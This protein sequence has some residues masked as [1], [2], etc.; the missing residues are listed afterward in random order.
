MD[1]FPL[2]ITGGQ[3]KNLAKLADWLED[4]DNKDFPT[5]FDMEHVMHS[6]ES[7]FTMERPALAEYGY[8]GTTACALGHGPAAGVEPLADESWLEYRKRAFGTMQDVDDVDPLYD[9]LFC[10]MWTIT[11]NTAS[12]AVKRIRYALE[13]GIPDNFQDQAAR[14][15]PLSYTD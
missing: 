6:E 11:D 1:H 14:R 13:H 15:A 10:A 7:G 2:R 4:L 3:K 5:G 12:G 8:C 9:F